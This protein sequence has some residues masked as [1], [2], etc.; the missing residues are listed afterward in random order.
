MVGIPPGVRLK[1]TVILARQKKDYP[2][3]ILEGGESIIKAG[4]GR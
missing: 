3:G 4:D 1:N 2:N